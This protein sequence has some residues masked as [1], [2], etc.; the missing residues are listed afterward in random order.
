MNDKVLDR[1]GMPSATN[2]GSGHLQNSQLFPWHVL[3]SVS[4]SWD[5][6]RQLA[7]F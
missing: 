4:I 5:A 6:T 3:N 1:H 2:D 7:S